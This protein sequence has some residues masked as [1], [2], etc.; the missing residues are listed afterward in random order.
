MRA[1]SS[2]RRRRRLAW[3]GAVV[4]AGGAAAAAALVLA[5]PGTRL[6][7]YEAA[8][9][10]PPARAPVAAQQGAGPALT[11][12]DRVAIGRVVTSFADH[13]I[14]RRDPLAAYGLATPAMRA[15][16]TR[17]QWAR[18]DLPVMPYPSKLPPRWSIGPAGHGGALVDLT[19]SSSKTD[20][21]LFT[22]QLKRIGSRWL[23]DSV[24]PTVTIGPAGQVQSFRDLRPGAG[25]P[26]LAKARLGAVW[27]LLPVG[28]LAALMLVPIAIV[29]G[30]RR[31]RRSLRA[32]G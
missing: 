3:L 32:A 26:S 28:I 15:A 18:G 31:T 6:P 13:G 23:V 9:Y 29:L 24:V 25:G 20:E 10:T 17:A 11:A 4:A 30:K 22:M 27:L 7:S 19:L 16:A 8:P 5:S 14:A 1:L 12:T 21:Q 2:P